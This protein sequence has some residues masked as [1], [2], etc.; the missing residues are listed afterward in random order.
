VAATSEWPDIALAMGLATLIGVLGGGKRGVRISPLLGRLPLGVVIDVDVVCPSGLKVFV[1][2]GEVRGSDT[3]DA[4]FGGGSNSDAWLNRLETKWG[5]GENV[6]LDGLA[7]SRGDVADS[8]DAWLNDERK[9]GDGREPSECCRCRVTEFAL[10][11]MLI[12]DLADGSLWLPSGDDG[13]GKVGV[14]VGLWMAGSMSLEFGG[15]F[16]WMLTGEVAR[17][18][19]G[20]E[21][22]RSRMA[23]EGVA[24][25]T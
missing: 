17:E 11:A 13:L 19:S 7:K 16:M 15:R 22:F 12:S 3:V 9:P 4:D 25:F 2:S 8:G 6:E 10:S 23:D 5:D 1:F 18:S 24:N 20:K 21:N 14:E